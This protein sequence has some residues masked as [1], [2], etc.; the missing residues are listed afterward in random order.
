V[1]AKVGKGLVKRRG[2]PMKMG[3]IVLGV[4]IMGIIGSGSVYA[5][6]KLKIGFID[7]QK[8]LNNSRAG[9]EAKEVLTK[10]SEER[11]DILE[12]QDK[13]MKALVE[14]LERKGSALSKE[15]RAKKENELKS[16]QE[17]FRKTLSKMELELQ[18]KDF[19][20]SQVILK[21]LEE[22]I[23]NI[24][25]KGKY[26]I[27]FEKNEGAVLYAPDKYDLSDQVIRLYDEEKKSQ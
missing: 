3:R 19:E 16:M 23:E 18:R 13:E 15:A 22:I 21:D 9:M 26:S 4:M 6:E 20:L 11:K 8:V 5:G 14:E 17:D 2:G 25:K 1:K 12:K 7:V 27:I 10:E 24:G